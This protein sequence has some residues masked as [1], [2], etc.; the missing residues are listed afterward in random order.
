MEN[1]QY[2]RYYFTFSKQKTY[3]DV[4]LKYFDSI[5]KDEY[6]RERIMKYMDIFESKQD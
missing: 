5:L 6:D 4:I 2:L 1:L 3:I